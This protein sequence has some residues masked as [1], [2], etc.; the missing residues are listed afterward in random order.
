[1]Q[2]ELR[3][4]SPPLHVTCDFHPYQRLYLDPAIEL[5]RAELE[6]VQ[7]NISTNPDDYRRL[8]ASL[9][10]E[11]R[12]IY[13]A[14]FEK[15]INVD[16]G[17]D[18]A[19]Y[20][21]ML[22]RCA[23]L[24]AECEF[25]QVDKQPTSD[26]IPLVLMVRE[27]IPAYKAMVGGAVAHA[28]AAISGAAPPTIIY[29]PGDQTKSSYRMVEK[30]LT[31]GPNRAYPDCSQILDVFGCI[32]DCH[33]YAAMAAV[34][35][36]FAD[37]HKSGAVQIARMKDRWNT[38]SEG[39]WRDLMLNIVV[40]GKVIFEV[41][42]VLHA[43]LVARKALDAHT[44][45]NQF[46]SFA[47]VFGLLELSMEVVAGAVVVDG[48]GEDGSDEWD[49]G[50]ASGGAVAAT[51]TARVV[52]LEAKVAQLE[53]KVAAVEAEKAELDAKVA[54]LTADNAIAEAKVAAAV[55]AERAAVEVERDAD[56]QQFEAKVAELQAQLA[57]RD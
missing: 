13:N 56:K 43:M 8:L 35:D 3:F 37:Q 57:T 11:D 46:R 54:V 6:R 52:E 51:T 4:A 29:R 26:L 7:A 12:K 15:S 53:G 42:V 55:V 32:I 33:D 40:N 27:Q 19:A 25:V 41:Q 38:P 45:Y 22:E 23:A 24:K 18:P 16:L 14:S 1:L 48:R 2:T 30:A 44:A 34:V 21:T 31:K 20:V 39:G 17:G 49:A 9:S 36:A 28:T 5:I 50:A 10:S 47:E